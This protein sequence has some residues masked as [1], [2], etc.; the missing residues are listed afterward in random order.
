MPHPSEYDGEFRERG[1]R[2]FGER[3][4]GSC[5]RGKSARLGGV[6]PRVGAALRRSEALV[7]EGAIGGRRQARGEAGPGVDEDGAEIE[8]SPAAQRAILAWSLSTH[9]RRRGRARRRASRT[10]DR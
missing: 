5:A 7:G 1:V 8:I 2:V 9:T 6:G 4:P 3:G 10:P